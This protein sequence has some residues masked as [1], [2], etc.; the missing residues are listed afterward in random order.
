MASIRKIFMVI[1][2]AIAYFASLFIL[3]LLR[4]HQIEWGFLD[5]NI[6]LFA[7]LFPIW[8]ITAYILD[9][10]QP[11]KLR[12]KSI[13]FKNLLLSIVIFVLF[14]TIFLYIFGGFFVAQPKTNLIL[15]S[16]IFLVLAYLAKSVLSSLFVS[17]K[18][19]VLF[20][21]DNSATAQLLSHLQTNPGLG[22]E[23]KMISEDQNKE[24]KSIIDQE[25]GDVIV[26]FPDACIDKRFIET[27]YN[28]LPTK[29]DIYKL[30]DFYELIFLKEPLEF[31]DEGWFV[32]N[33]RSK[34]V[35]NLLKRVVDIVLS[36]LLLVILC[37]I[38]LL[39]FL[40]IKIFSPGKA[41]F[42]QKRRGKN[43]KDFT[44][45]KFRTMTPNHDN[46]P[47]TIENDPRITKIGKIFRSTHLDEL[48]QLYNILIGEMSFVGPRAESSNLADLYSKNIPYYEIRNTVKPGLTGWAQIHYKPSV[49]VVEGAEK[50]KYDFFYIKNRSVI[51]DFLIL[52]KTIKLIFVNPK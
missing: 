43:N 25:E 37:P 11:P 14:S 19:K 23:P 44:T 40:A 18:T 12:N 16:L 15:F 27:L 3:D 20:L 35:F 26:I 38:F 45:Y 17:L 30:S 13:L 5:Q 29:A 46:N 28:L 8:A 41:I 49:S 31:L 10:W 39:C 32:N 6:R 1:V 22:Y 47:W 52:L 42:C 34:R 24:L 36:L 9:L 51:L 50:L 33:L 48:P 21:D 7:F 2:D 4:Y